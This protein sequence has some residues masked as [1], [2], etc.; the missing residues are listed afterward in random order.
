MTIR[1]LLAK[2]QQSAPDYLAWL[3]TQP[4]GASGLIGC[5]A[6]HRI[7]GRFSQRKVPDFEAMAITP[8]EHTQ[9]HAGMEEFVCQY[10]KTEW[11]MIAR[12]LLEAIRLGIFVYDAKAA[13]EL[14]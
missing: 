8:H 10:G 4:S 3:R 5:H 2:Q 6:H 13:R 14:A 11:E 7:G 12:H 1:D 9:L